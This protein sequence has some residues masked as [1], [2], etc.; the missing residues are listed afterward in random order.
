MILTRVLIL[1]WPSPGLFPN[2]KGHWTDKAEEKRKHKSDCYYLTKNQI[3][4]FKWQGGRIPLKIIFYPPHCKYDLDNCLAA[5]KAGLDG[6]ADA[7][8]MNDRMFRPIT[9][10]FGDVKE[11]GEVMIEFSA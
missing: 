4:L 6:V 1:T 5:M 7:L 8:K 3:K 11:H 2:K 9:I 10:D